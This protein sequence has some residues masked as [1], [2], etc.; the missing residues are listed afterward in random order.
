MESRID[1][2]VAISKIVLNFFLTGIMLKLLEMNQN[3]SFK[4]VGRYNFREHKTEFEKNL[5]EKYFYTKIVEKVI[6]SLVSK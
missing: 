3:F 1:E 4:I 2:F 5:R 6:V